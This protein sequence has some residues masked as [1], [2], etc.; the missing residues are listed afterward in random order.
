MLFL[1]FTYYYSGG[2]IIKDEVGRA[3]VTKRR[4]MNTV[5]VGKYEGKRSLGRPTHQWEDNMKP[6]LKKQDGSTWNICNW[7]STATDDK[8]L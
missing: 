4:N 2:P 3:C 5:F 7:L 1:Q 8:L 6:N